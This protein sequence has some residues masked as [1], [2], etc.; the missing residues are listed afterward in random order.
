MPKKYTDPEELKVY[1][2]DKRIPNRY[3]D[4]EE[5]I[6]SRTD[7]KIPKPNIYRR[8][9]LTRRDKWILKIKDSEQIQGS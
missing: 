6:R 3:R 2:R 5:I 9:K 4:P 8:D 1:R 7:T